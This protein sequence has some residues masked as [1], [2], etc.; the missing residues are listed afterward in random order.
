MKTIAIINCGSAHY[1]EKIL[2]IIAQDEVSG[3]IFNLSPQNSNEISSQIFELHPS[4]IIIT[5]SP[6]HLYLSSARI[7]PQDFA[8]FVIKDPTPLLGICY[9]HQML[10]T[11]FGGRVIKNPKGLELGPHRIKCNEFPYPL[12]DGLKKNFF[13]FMG[14]YDTISQLPQNFHNFA[15][16]AKT[17][18]VAIQFFQN[19]ESFPIFGVQFHPE[20]SC[21]KVCNRI[22]SN[23][24]E[25][26]YEN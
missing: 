17:Q 11:L 6:D 20:M 24:I 13:A 26:C 8:D 4:G 19:E 12:F 22:F 5:G 25:I 1:A 15:T 7:L 14:H 16:T 23:F 21:K 2:N 18:Y 9:G 10:A 3:Q